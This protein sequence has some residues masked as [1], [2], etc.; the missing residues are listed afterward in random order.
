[1]VMPSQAWK[2]LKRRERINP[3]TGSSSISDKIA[4]K[5]VKQAK[6]VAYTQADK[7]DLEESL[8]GIF[9]SWEL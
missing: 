9:E 7:D 8:K 2:N 1:M 4:T 5:L 6:T 3:L